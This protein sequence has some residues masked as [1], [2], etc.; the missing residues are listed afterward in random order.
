VRLRALPENTKFFTA[1]TLTI[2][3][4]ITVITI[5]V[6]FSTKAELN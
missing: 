3:A 2:T 4:T 1:C 5:G 6:R